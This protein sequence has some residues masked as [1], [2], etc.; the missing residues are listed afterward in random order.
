MMMAKKH[1]IMTPALR[2]THVFLRS[3]SHD[4]HTQILQLSTS[5]QG[6]T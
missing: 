1:N 5:A 3:I 4:P 2:L 6:D